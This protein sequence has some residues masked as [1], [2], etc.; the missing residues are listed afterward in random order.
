MGRIEKF[1]PLPGYFIG[2]FVF[3]ARE[4]STRDMAREKA[5]SI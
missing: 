5:L 4:R 3:L 1:A 2:Y